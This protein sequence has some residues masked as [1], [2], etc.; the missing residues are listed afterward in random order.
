M[1]D[2][3]A[4]LIPKDGDGDDGTESYNSIRIDV[5]SNGYIA[6]FISESG[7]ITEVYTDKKELIK[8][9]TRCL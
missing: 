7:E 8:E 1:N 3:L 4:R 9:L 5:V 6:T 2:N